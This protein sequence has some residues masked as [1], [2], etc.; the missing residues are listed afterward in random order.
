V[1]ADHSEI[2]GLIELG[3]W[4]AAH[5]A[6]QVRSD[7]LSCLIHAYLHRLEGDSSNAHYWYTRAGE[8]FPDNNLLQELARLQ[9]LAEEES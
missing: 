7:T 8:T 2:L 6:V 3:D 5:R 9:V 1:S 4:E